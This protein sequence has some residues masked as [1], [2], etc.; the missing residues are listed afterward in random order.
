MRDCTH[1]CCDPLSLPTLTTTNIPAERTTSHKAAHNIDI[2]TRHT[3]SKT[4]KMRN[5][6]T[7]IHMKTELYREGLTNNAEIEKNTYPSLTED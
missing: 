3:K 4:H 1:K 2:L 5:P 7:T 6:L